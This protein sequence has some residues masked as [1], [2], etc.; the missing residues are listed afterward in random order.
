MSDLYLYRLKEPPFRRR[1]RRVI[2]KRQ[3]ADQ[4]SWRW[5][6][7]SFTERLDAWAWNHPVLA[8]LCDLSIFVAAVALL[9]VLGTWA[10]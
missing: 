9:V 6:P 1:S 4:F 3:R 7:D 10:A 2:V 8:F 5:K